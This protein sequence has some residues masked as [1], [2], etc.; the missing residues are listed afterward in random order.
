M[1]WVT[2]PLLGFVASMILVGLKQEES[3]FKPLWCSIFF[4]E[5][6]GVSFFVL[7]ALEIANPGWWPAIYLLTE[8][9]SLAPDAW[10]IIGLFFFLFPVSF[11]VV[12]FRFP[13]RLM[14]W[15]S[16]KAEES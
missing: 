8:A 13:F 9:F 2:I 3:F 4:Y 6:A 7:G 1:A 5:L 11:L 15:Q 10:R 12:L 16:K 14:R